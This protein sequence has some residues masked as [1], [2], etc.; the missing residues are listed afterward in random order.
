[1]GYVYEHG[2]GVAPDAKKARSWYGLA[3]AKGHTEA[4]RTL[5]LME[6]TGEGGNVDRVAAFLLY[7]QLLVLHDKDA[8]RYLATLR[9]E[10]TPKEWDSLQQPLVHMRIDPAKLDKILQHTKR[11]TSR[12]T[13]KPSI[14]VSVCQLSGR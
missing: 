2:L 1:M 12:L 11:A 14:E 5:A 10:I 7:A 3:A 6:T 13:R 9:R 4:M 8:L